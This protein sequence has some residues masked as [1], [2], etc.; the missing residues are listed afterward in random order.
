MTTGRERSTDLVT[1]S[2]G[3][4]MAPETKWEPGEMETGGI[5]PLGDFARLFG[6]FHHVFSPRGLV[7]S[8]LFW[9]QA[10]GRYGMQ[11]R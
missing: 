10:S 3:L 11:S 7:K 6:Q 8:F 5:P 4:L 1:M 9:R 2:G